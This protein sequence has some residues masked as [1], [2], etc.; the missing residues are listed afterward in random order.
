MIRE[1][2]QEE[3]LALLNE[4]Q[5]VLVQDLC[6]HFQVTPITIRRDLSELEAAGKLVRT[7]GGALPVQAQPLLETPFS[8]SPDAYRYTLHIKEKNLIA[9]T[10]LK[11]IQTGQKLFLSSGSTVFALSGLLHT[12]PKLTVVTDAIPLAYKLSFQS[13]INLVI[14]VGELMGHTLSTTGVMAENMIIHFKFDAA[15]ISLTALDKDGQMYL[16]NI[17]EFG[18][19]QSLFSVVD[20]VYILV[21][22]SKIGHDDFIRVGKLI[23]NYTIITDAISDEYLQIYQNMDIDVIVAK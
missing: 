6:E 17:A 23:P 5:T 7:H 4:Q 1:K 21:D 20:K 16:N 3:I 2:R 18:I 13:N 12:I 22:S 9:Q 11:Q 15:F 14:I 10:A 8:G 19:M